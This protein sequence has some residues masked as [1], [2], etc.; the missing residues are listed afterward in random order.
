MEIQPTHLGILFDYYHV[1]VQN[2]P[3]V[4]LEVLLVQAEAYES[5]ATVAL[6]ALM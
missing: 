6:S 4:V 2:D 3:F 1:W 5:F